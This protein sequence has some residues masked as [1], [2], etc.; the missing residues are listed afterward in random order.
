MHSV[1]SW[2]NN[3]QKN[4]EIV[5]KLNK[6]QQLL[7]FGNNNSYGDASI[8]QGEYQFDYKIDYED[9]KFID[10]K[11]TIS[12]YMYKYKNTL[13]SIP[14]KSDVTLG[15][16]VAS[17]VHGKDSFYNGSFI[18]NVKS[19]K[20]FTSEG[21]LIECDRKNNLDLFYTTVGGYGLTGAIVGIELFQNNYLNNLL[22][23]TKVYTGS[24]I[25]NL[26]RKF[27]KINTGY[28]VAW[29]DTL[30]KDM[31]WVLEVSHPTE[32]ENNKVKNP[33]DHFIKKFIS[34]AS[35]PFIG[36]NRFGIMSL[37]N[38]IYFYLKSKQKEY[39]KNF[40]DVVYPLNLF[41]DTRKVSK[42]QKI[43]QV[44][45]S[46]PEKSQNSLSDL[47]SLLIENQSPILC[48]FKR[49][50]KNETNLNLSF[51]QQGWAVAVDFPFYEFDTVAIRKFIKVLV[52]NNGKIY[53]AK[54]SII[55]ADEFQKMYPNYSNWINITR[56][57]DPNSIFKSSMSK[58][59]N[60]K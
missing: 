7:S 35:L 40:D 2:G 18:R 34:T 23:E 60:I 9:S 29:V 36:K 1:S 44:Q 30:S 53:L 38:K 19:L 17:D 37:V 42:K 26:L 48:S 27:S 22:F 55:T 10:P 24:R 52:E 47:I 11:M 50:G 3:F 46:I 49:L 43:I 56:K 5:N 33:N 32:I 58:R 16:A 31:S 14:G 8:P 28:S 4:L 51:I 59:L 39:L 20:I 21:K 57:Y 54:D 15:G 45:F 12:S 13:T 6:K 25:E 41:T